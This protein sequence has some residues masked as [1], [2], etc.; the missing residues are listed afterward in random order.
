MSRELDTMSVEKQ[1][2][3]QTTLGWEVMYD[4]QKEY[5][6]HL[7]FILRSHMDKLLEDIISKIRALP[8]ECGVM[9]ETKSHHDPK[10]ILLADE[11]TAVDGNELV[12]QGEVEVVEDNVTC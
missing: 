9:V 10:V 7:A 3:E 12:N 5:I 1:K 8:R 6:D 2:V 11:A 4:A